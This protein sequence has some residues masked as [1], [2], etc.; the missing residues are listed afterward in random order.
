MSEKICKNCRFVWNE[1]GGYFCR[2]YPPYV[3]MIPRPG[4][5]TGRG[6][7]I[8]PAGIFPPVGEKSTCGEF[9]PIVDPIT[10]N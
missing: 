7:E 5:A 6:T 2:R 8:A 10:V 1:S 3:V 9:Q 4:I